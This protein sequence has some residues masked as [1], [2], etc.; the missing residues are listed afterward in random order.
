MK[1]WRP[2]PP[3]WGGDSTPVRL[4]DAPIDLQAIT[5]AI[6]NIQAARVIEL[7]RGRTF[8]KPFHLAIPR[9][10]TGFHVVRVGRQ[11]L[12]GPLRQPVTAAAIRVA[13]GS[14]DWLSVW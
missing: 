13:L 8:Q 10:L 1:A 2:G 9:F 12:L 6:D 5:A 7:D 11:H 3:R 4:I 14:A